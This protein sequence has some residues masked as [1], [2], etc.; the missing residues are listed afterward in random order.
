[1]ANL[2]FLL[3]SAAMGTMDGILPGQLLVDAQAAV[4][5]IDAVAE[6]RQ[7]IKLPNLQFE[8][9][10]K[11]MCGAAGRPAGCRGSVG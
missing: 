10:I 2:F 5:E 8:L 3:I 7:L 9:A 6:D 1:M 4:V 11:P